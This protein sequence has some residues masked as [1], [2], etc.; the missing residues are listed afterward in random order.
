MRKIVLGFTLALAPAFAAAQD[1]TCVEMSTWF[2]E[3]IPNI[4]DAT[5]LNSADELLAHPTR[6]L[7]AQQSFAQS[8][9]KLQQGDPD[10]FWRALLVVSDGLIKCF[11]TATDGLSE[12]QLAAAEQFELDLPIEARANAATFALE[13]LGGSL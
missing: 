3:K 8:L 13:E 7:I 2:L 11:E 5:G 9:T 4:K 1:E 12:E 6:L 10:M